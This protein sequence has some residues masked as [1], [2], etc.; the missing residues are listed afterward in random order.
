MG[1]RDLL[2]GNQA[3][4]SDPHLCRL[5]SQRYRVADMERVADLP[6][7]A[8][9]GLP[10]FMEARLQAFLYPDEGGTLGQTFCAAYSEQIWDSRKRP[11]AEGA[12]PN[13]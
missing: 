10:E 12:T 13:P 7:H 4:A 8:H 6:T 3:D 11:T 1:D 2:Q 9:H 5:Q